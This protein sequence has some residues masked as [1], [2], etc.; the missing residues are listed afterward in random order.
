LRMNRTA[1]LVWSAVALV[2][3]LTVI[4]PAALF[5]SVKGRKNTAIGLG[6]AAVYSL[7]RGHTGTGVALAAGSAYAY[8]RYKDKKHHKHTTRHRRWYTKNGHR[9]YYY[10]KR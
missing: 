1:R 4:A 6:A 5:A 10:S 7:S 9:H 2:F 3:L 8:K